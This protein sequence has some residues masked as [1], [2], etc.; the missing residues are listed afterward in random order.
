MKQ[1]KILTPTEGAED[2]RRLLA[3]PDRQWREGF[4]AKSVAERW[5]KVGALP[6]EIAG[7]FRQCGLLDAEP[8]LAAPEFKT[9][10]PGGGAAS[11]SDV[12][13]V[14][15]TSRGVFAATIEA[16]VAE[17]FGETVGE[18][19][20]GASPGKIQRLTFLCALPGVSFPPRSDLRYQLFHRCGAALIEAERFG[21][22]GAAM[23]VHSF[24]LTKEW[25]G[26]F[27]AFGAAIGVHAEGLGPAVIS[28][29]SSRPLLVGWAQG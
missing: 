13:A 3:K 28:V 12:F 1:K 24:S 19:L 10:L 23:I 20:L 21:F 2:W 17:P 6:P 22:Y 14:I 4:S 16:K 15:R 18:W 5:E 26:D 8:L 29:P 27:K 9:D 11:Q 25:S 7:Q